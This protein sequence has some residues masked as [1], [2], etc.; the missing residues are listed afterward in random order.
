[1]ERSKFKLRR[2]AVYTRKSSEESLEQE[3]NSLHT[4]TMGRRAL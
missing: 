2:C 1:M 4:A 3:F